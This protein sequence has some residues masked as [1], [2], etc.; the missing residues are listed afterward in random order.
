[1]YNRTI[2]NE[3]CELNDSSK[4]FSLLTQPNKK[5]EKP[6]WSEIIEGF[7]YFENYN[8]NS[9]FKLKKFYYEVDSL[10]DLE[11]LGID[12]NYIDHYENKFIHYIFGLSRESL[13]F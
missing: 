8:L 4:L 13:Y 12:Y 3:I 1:M 9:K 7:K 2:L 11:S 6:C 5:G 10:K